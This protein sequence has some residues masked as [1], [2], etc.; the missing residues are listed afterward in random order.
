MTTEAPMPPGGSL[1]IGG[2][3]YESVFPA[4]IAQLQSRAERA[5]ADAA[6]LRKNQRTPGADEE[7]P[8]CKISWAGNWQGHCI[9][10]LPGKFRKNCPIRAAL[11]QEA[12][13]SELARIGQEMGDYDPPPPPPTDEQTIRDE[14]DRARPEFQEMIRRDLGRISAPLPVIQKA[15]MRGDAV[16]GGGLSPMGFIDVIAS[17][18]ADDDTAYEDKREA[19][20][21]AR[22]IW[23][24]LRDA[25]W[26]IEHLATLHA[27]ASPAG[28]TIPTNDDIA[29]EIDR[30]SDEDRMNTY[31]PSEYGYSS[32]SLLAAKRIQSLF[33]KAGRT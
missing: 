14:A 9:D 8:H 13:K 2:V 1:P 5:E 22:R 12:A 10:S 29:R 31:V 32:A 17:H 21:Q 11:T 3:P 33:E 27:A 20:E 24:A 19:I 18:L 6:I 23:G 16:S 4:A 15:S 30:A 26:G 28:V 7:C 25:G